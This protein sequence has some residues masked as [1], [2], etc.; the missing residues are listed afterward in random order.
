L[1]L[2]VFIFISDEDRSIP[3]VE[4][5]LSFPKCDIY[6]QNEESPHY[7]FGF[8]KLPNYWIKAFARKI[9]LIK[10]DY[11]VKIYYKIASSVD[12]AKWGIELNETYF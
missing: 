7:Y 2:T 5:F 10:R 1:D 12:Y 6:Y 9:D 11:G 8:L 4:H 3:W